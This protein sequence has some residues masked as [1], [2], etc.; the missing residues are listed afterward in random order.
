[1]GKL[2]A[3]GQS[4]LENV[5]ARRLAGK[6]SLDDNKKVCYGKVPLHQMLSLR[7]KSKK[8]PGS[9]HRPDCSLSAVFNEST[10][11]RSSKILDLQN[12][13]SSACKCNCTSKVTYSQFMNDESQV[14]SIWRISVHH[15][16]RPQ[17]K[18]TDGHIKGR[19]LSKCQYLGSSR[20]RSARD[21]K[22]KKKKILV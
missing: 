14:G 4:S 8:L 2:A 22:K 3:S 21:K 6:R 1:M 7:A 11:G 5:Q 9:D 19:R 20:R 17:P 18:G 15:V 12:S 16:D 10:R 13:T